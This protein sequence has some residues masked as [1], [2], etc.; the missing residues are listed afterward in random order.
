MFF[1]FICL[2]STQFVVSHDTFKRMI[3]EITCHELK[4]KLD[5]HESLVIVD[6]REDFEREISVIEPS[7]HIPLSELT[8][9]LNE[10]SENTAYVMQCR[11]G[12]RSARA[13]DILL[14]AGFKDVKN[15]V[16]GINQWA[17]EIDS[18]MSLY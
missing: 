18:S 11:S 17:L 15:L 4:S 10:L 6:V 1:I 12:G 14:S 7:I 16:G 13:A 8:S 5:A 3:P 9:R 2:G